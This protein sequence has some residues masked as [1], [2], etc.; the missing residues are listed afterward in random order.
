MLILLMVLFDNLAN[1][2]RMLAICSLHLG[3]YVPS[4]SFL[5]VISSLKYNGGSKG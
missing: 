3:C 5:N 1:S 4:P 2:R